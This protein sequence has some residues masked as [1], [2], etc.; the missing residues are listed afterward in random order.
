MAN[1]SGPQVWNLTMAAGSLEQYLF[2]FAYPSTGVLYPI[3]S[4]WQY[5][6]NNAAGSQVISVTG[7]ANSQGVLTIGT[8]G[9]TVQLN[10]YPAA[11]SSL[12]GQQL[13]HALWQNPGSATTAYCWLDGSLIVGPAPQP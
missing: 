8:A 7:T 12:G 2:T 4:T 5:V 6:A 11:T 10:L 3:T 9:S 13:T 1:S